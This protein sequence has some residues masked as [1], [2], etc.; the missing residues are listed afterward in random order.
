MSVQVASL[1]EEEPRPTRAQRVV[2]KASQ[3][4][5]YFFCLAPI[6]LFPVGLAYKILIYFFP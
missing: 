6:A 2:G 1:A 3:Y 5:L 4:L